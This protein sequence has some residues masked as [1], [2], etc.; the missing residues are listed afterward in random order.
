MGCATNL[1]ATWGS[2]SAVRFRRGTGWRMKRPAVVPGKR[3]LMTSLSAIPL[4]IAAKGSGIQLSLT[5]VDYVM[6]AIYF[7]VVLGI[8]FIARR[9]GVLARNVTFRPGIPRRFRQTFPKVPVR[10]FGRRRTLGCTRFP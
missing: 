9:R 7:V 2:G 3:Q 10:S 6:L 4:A 8:G 1:K 5:W